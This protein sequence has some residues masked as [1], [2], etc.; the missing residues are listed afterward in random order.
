MTFPDE[1][2]EVAA[3][4][5]DRVVLVTYDG[6]AEPDRQLVDAGTRST[7]S[8]ASTASSFPAWPSRCSRATPTRADGLTVIGTTG[9]RA[10]IDSPGRGPGAAGPDRPTAPRCTT[11]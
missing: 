8:S 3:A 4:A 1:A 10:L 6:G 5:P 2:A 7:A 11:A 9:D